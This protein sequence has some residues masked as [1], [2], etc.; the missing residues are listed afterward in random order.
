M[1][2]QKSLADDVERIDGNVNGLFAKVSD[3]ADR[4][5]D[6]EEEN[7]RLREELQEAKNDAELAVAVAGETSDRARADGG[8]TK[9]KR[10]ELLSRNEVVRRAITTAGK[11]GAVTA[12]DVVDMA[13]PETNLHHR[14][15]HDAWD[16]LVSRWGSIRVQERDDAANRLVVD[17]DDLEDELVRLVDDDLS[18]TQLAEELHRGRT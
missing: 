8:P 15:V 4:V 10:A 5:D 12:G 13:R 1:S 2:T 14:T 11:G 18:D 17:R 6:L 3:L 16:K 7:E 9:V